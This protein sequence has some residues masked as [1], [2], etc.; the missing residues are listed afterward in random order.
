MQWGQG[1]AYEASRRIMDYGFS[2]LPIHRV[3]VETISENARARALAQ[4]L[5]M[6]MEGELRHHRFIRGRWWDTV[7]CAVLKDEWNPGVAL[8]PHAD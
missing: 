6:R 7:I 5:G 4:R 3:Y 1:Y 8:P 2:S